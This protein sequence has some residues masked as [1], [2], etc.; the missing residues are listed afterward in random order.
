ML[1]AD[2]PGRRTD[3]RPVVTYHADANYNDSA[4]GWQ[5]NFQ[6]H[7]CGLNLDA[8]ALRSNLTSIA[9]DSFYGIACFQ[10]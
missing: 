8:V 5:E 4:G 10:V 1:Q 3:G 9:T 2:N 7:F 6:H